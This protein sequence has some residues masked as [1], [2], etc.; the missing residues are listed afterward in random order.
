MPPPGSATDTELQQLYLY[1][2]NL[3]TQGA[4]KIAKSLQ[5]NSSL[6][7]LNMKDNNFGDEAADDIATILSC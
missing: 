4:I 2:I 6:T 1:N 5:N 3:Q 7:V